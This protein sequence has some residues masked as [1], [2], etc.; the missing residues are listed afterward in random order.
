M[1][2]PHKKKAHTLL[3][4]EESFKGHEV[5][6][7]QQRSLSSKCVKLTITPHIKALDYQFYNVTLLMPH[8]NIS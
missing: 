5:I 3:T 8:I 6:R 7:K 2:L 1:S 4:Y